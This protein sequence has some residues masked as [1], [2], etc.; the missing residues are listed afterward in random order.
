MK[1]DNQWG[2]CWPHDKTPVLI[3][4]ELMCSLF[5]DALSE[6]ERKMR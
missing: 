6:P 3:K 2:E 5:S 4:D 1:G